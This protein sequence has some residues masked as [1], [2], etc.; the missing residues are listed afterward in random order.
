MTLSPL[1]VK[2]SSGQTSKH[3]A[4]PSQVEWSMMTMAMVFSPFVQRRRYAPRSGLAEQPVLEIRGRRL[5]AEP[6]CEGRAH[7][8][9]PGDG[10]YILAADGEGGADAR[11]VSKAHL[12]ALA[13]AVHR[14]EEALHLG[15]VLREVGG[16]VALE[17]FAE[18]VG[19][20]PLA[21]R[22]EEMHH[23]LLG[24][25]GGKEDGGI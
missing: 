15:A 11:N 6:D 5:G 2:T 23:Q 18:G 8:I 24:R 14:R 16:R 4:L 25:V 21:G 17:A 12:L 9:R 7:E 19:H 1:R 20:L 22:V 13:H 10:H 3:M